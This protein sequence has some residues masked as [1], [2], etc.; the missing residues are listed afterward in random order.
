MMDNYD[1]IEEYLSDECST[2]LEEVI[3]DFLI[4]KL[5]SAVFNVS[6]Y[7][8]ENNIPIMQDASL[9]WKVFNEIV[10]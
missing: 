9:G 10:D 7:F 4:E 8:K 2:D 1:D 5:F 3:D 6:S